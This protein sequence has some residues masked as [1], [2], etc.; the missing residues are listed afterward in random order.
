MATLYPSNID[1]PTSLPIATDTVT[2]VAAASVN[3][4]RATILALENTLG[5]DPAGIYTTVRYRLDSLEA[6]ILGPGGGTTNFLAG[7]DLTGSAIDQ[8]VVGLQGFGISPIPPA[9]G[10]ALI[11]NGTVWAGANI[12]SGITLDNDLGGTTASPTVVGLYNHPLAPTT[13]VASAVPVYDTSLSRYDVRQLTLDDV[14]PKFAIDSFSG[15]STVD[16]GASV[17]HPVFTASYSALPESAE[18]TNSDGINSPL[19]LFPPFTSG[20]VGGTFTHNIITSV[21]FTLTAIGAT[22]QSANQ[23]ITYQARSFGGVGAPGATGVTATGTTSSPTAFLNTGTTMNSLGLFS[24]SVGATFGPFSPNNQKIYLLLTG[25]NHTFKD[26]STGLGF[27]FLSPPT[28]INFFNLYSAYV[29]M[30]LYES[31]N[32]LAQPF[33]VLVYT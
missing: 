27:T 22:T 28:P 11:W 13:P 6:A 32:T 31:T 30:Y 24:S 29:S 21:T 20:T 18:I 14:G 33:S 12:P 10:Q 8:T 5:V 7:G 19:P 9:M 26:P 23:F 16:V 17:V 3:N 1:N 15:G 25:N 4:L 2:P